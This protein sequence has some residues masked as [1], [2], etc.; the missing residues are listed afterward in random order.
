MDT[1]SIPVHGF[2]LLMK[3]ENSTMRSQSRNRYLLPSPFSFFIMARHG[4]D[5]TRDCNRAIQAA[6]GLNRPTIHVPRKGARTCAGEFG[7]D[8]VGSRAHENR[9]SVAAAKLC[10]DAI[11]LATKNNP[12]SPELANAIGLLALNADEDVPD[13]CAA[14]LPNRKVTSET[15]EFYWTPGGPIVKGLAAA[16]QFICFLYRNMDNDWRILWR[17]LTGEQQWEWYNV[18]VA[19]GKDYRRFEPETRGLAGTDL[20]RIRNR[21]EFTAALRHSPSLA[22]RPRPRGHNIS[23]RRWRSSSRRDDRTVRRRLF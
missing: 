13:G 2:D 12:G 23:E 3:R 6:V 21:Q 14:R 8:T 10:L 1:L 9:L 20:Y 16:N 5:A 22:D 19:C 4:F 17:E 15:V 11:P 18:W 7:D